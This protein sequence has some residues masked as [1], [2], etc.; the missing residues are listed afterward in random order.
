MIVLDRLTKRYGNAVSVDQLSLT[1]PTGTICALVGAS[2]GGKTTTLRLIN[3]LI[4]ADEGRVLIDGTDAASLA[5]VA[6]RRRIGYVI[7]SVGLFPHW[8][9]A[10]NIATVPDLLGWKRDRIDR[11]I[12]ELLDLVGLDPASYRHRRPHEL[13]GGQQ[14][15]VGVARALAADPDL[16]LMD[17]PFGALDPVTRDGLQ[18]ALLD[19]QARTGKTIVIVTHDIDEAIR[20]AS[21][22]AVLDGGKLIQHGSPHDL[23]ARPANAFVEAFVG[24]PRR[25]LRLLQVTR[26]RER[27]DF[28]EPIGGTPIDADVTLDIALER[29]VTTGAHRLPVYDRAADRR[30]T[31]VLAAIA[32]PDGRQT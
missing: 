24:G 26:V 32:S 6:L 23:L 29:M 3:R 18:A 2:G 19:I 15:R 21:L 8:N 12:D 1:V 14:Q 28:S 7:Q 20:L 10:R 5:P 16:L 4:E 31:L 22:V 17:E 13:S 9:V 25:G 11:R 27:A 30:G